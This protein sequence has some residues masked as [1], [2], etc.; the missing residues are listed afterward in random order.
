MDGERV[1]SGLGGG[2]FEPE[3]FREGAREA[4]DEGGLEMMTCLALLLRPEIGL[5]F[6]RHL[7]QTH[8]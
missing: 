3:R 7:L 5:L 4:T 2:D 1:F 8:I 6:D